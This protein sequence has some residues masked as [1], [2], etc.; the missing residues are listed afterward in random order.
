[1][2]AAVI[3]GFGAAPAVL[4]KQLTASIPIVFTSSADPIKLGLVESLSKPGANITGVSYQAV[5]LNAKRIEIL[6]ELAPKATQIGTFVNPDYP[7]SASELADLN[8]VVTGIGRELRT[9][10][11][12][13]ES[14]LDAGFASLKSSNAAALIINGDAFFNRMRGR[15][16]AL[17]AAHAMPAI[18]PW[19]EYAKDGGLIS[20]GPSLRD[21]FRQAGVY[22]GKIL[23]GTPPSDL[24]VL[25]PVKFELVLNA[26]TAKT[27]GLDVPPTLLARTSDVID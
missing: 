22:A 4:V 17:A 26:R 25:Q 13:A 18:Y 27:L 24:P 10:N 5:E 1:M 19:P 11:I 7:D 21:G 16:I 23:K 3:V 2:P 15:I 14:D 9:A 8:A 20:Y 6:S 12:R